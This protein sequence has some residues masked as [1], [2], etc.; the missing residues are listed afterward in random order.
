[1]EVE[2]DRRHWFAVP[3]EEL[4]P[5]LTRVQDYQAWWPWLRRFDGTAFE[6][7][8]CWNC[9]VQ[10]P[11]PYRLRFELRL[12]AVEPGRAVSAS[13]T[14]DIQGS[15]RIEVEPAEGGSE[16]RLVSR[17]EPASRFLKIVSRSVRPIARFG[18]DWVIDTGLGQFD[19]RAL[20]APRS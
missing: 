6:A 17:L 2:S 13:I 14:G 16:L 8:Q 11:L 3:P 10:P 12:E 5:T 15:A 4:W 7:G 18:H 20:G 9:A 1:M 19:A